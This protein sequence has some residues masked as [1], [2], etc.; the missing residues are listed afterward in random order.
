MRFLALL[1]R[2][3]VLLALYG[4]AP[5]EDVEEDEYPLRA[6]VWQPERACGVQEVP[7]K[8]SRLL[9]VLD[10]SSSMSL[11]V[12]DGSTDRWTASATAAQIAAE[13]LHGGTSV[14]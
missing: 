5:A 2:I 1:G 7:R 10:R 14:G 8:P 11:S 9:L 6:Q 13:E 12:A 3:V 4:F